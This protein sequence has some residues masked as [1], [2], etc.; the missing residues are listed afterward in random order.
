MVFNCTNHKAFGNWESIC[1]HGEC[2]YDECICNEGYTIDSAFH[3]GSLCTLE[4]TIVN[5]VLHKIIKYI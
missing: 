5:L 1:F 2:I 4:E 3:I